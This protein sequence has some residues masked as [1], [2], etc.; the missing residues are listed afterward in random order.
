[1]HTMSS[2]LRARSAHETLELVKPL[3]KRLGITRV[4]DTTW[5]DRVGIP[6]FASIRPKALSG[7]LCVNAG[8]GC[9]PDEAKIGAYMEAIEFAYAE[10]G[11][12]ELQAV[13]ST[14]RE[15]AGTFPSG[16]TFA[17]LCPRYGHP[18]DPD[19]L[20]YAVDAHSVLDDHLVR[21]PSELVFIPHS[22]NDGQK[23]FGESSNGLSSGNSV[24]EASV[25]GLYE[26]MERDVQSF[27]FLH[28]QS[29]LVNLDNVP[30]DVEKLVCLIHGAGLQLVVRYTQNEFK[31]PYFQAFLT[32]QVPE[33]PVSIATGTGFHCSK[34]IALVRAICEAA[35]SRLSHIHG[36]RDDIIRRVQYF[37]KVGRDAEIKAI[38]ELRTKA[39]SSAAAINY[40]EIFEPSTPRTLD[41]AWTHALSALERVDVRAIFR[42]T[43]T[44][45]SDQLQVVRIL[46]PGLESFDPN[47]KRLG[48]R[49]ASYAQKHL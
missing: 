36:G 33:M 32:E 19:G 13:P 25:H 39:F 23:P 44:N 37:D 28:D 15:M 35:Q 30:E 41:D 11:R 16:V 49:L 22:R 46:A 1:M 14:P 7:S 18:I 31:L 34:S 20:M 42:V 45:P 40:S 6:V 10:Y 4:T 48:P 29:A 24:L 47:L 43:F 2:S 21:I 26:L 9:H 38:N 8:K 3:A 27:D 17:S 12:T 5:L